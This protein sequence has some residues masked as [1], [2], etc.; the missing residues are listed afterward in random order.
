MYNMQKKAAV[1]F[2]CIAPFLAFI[3]STVGKFVVEGQVLGQIF[4]TCFWHRRY[5]AG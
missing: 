5:W 1:K 4:V 2:V 3:V